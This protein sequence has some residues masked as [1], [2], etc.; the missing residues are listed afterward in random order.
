MALQVR[1]VQKSGVVSLSSAVTT[2]LHEGWQPY[3]SPYVTA[4]AAAQVMFLPDDATP[5]P[6]A[7]YFLASKDGVM[8][9]GTIILERLEA[10]WNMFGE[11]LETQYGPTQAMTKGKFTIF[12]PNLGFGDGQPG[13]GEGGGLTEAEVKALIDAAIAALELPEEDQW[14]TYVDKGDQ[15]TLQ[16]AGEQANNAV[17]SLRV[18][19]EHKDTVVLDS[20]NIYTDEAIAKIPI[21]DWEGDFTRIEQ[22]IDELYN[23]VNSTADP[24]VSID[25]A[26]AEAIAHTDTVAADLRSE[27]NSADVAV[28]S[29]SK[30]Y[31]DAQL[32]TAK[33]NSERY[34]DNMVEYGISQMQ[35]QIS[36]G[37]AAA[38]IYADQQIAILDGSVDA[39]MSDLSQSLQASISSSAAD[40]Q[41]LAGQHADMG[42]TFVLQAANQYTDEKVASAATASTSLL[43]ETMEAVIAGAVERW[44]AD[45]KTVLEAAQVAYR[46]G[47]FTTPTGATAAPVSLAASD[48]GN[49]RTTLRLPAASSVPDGFTQQVLNI[50][51][52]V[53]SD[54]W[55]SQCRVHLDDEDY[56]EGYKVHT[57]RSVISASFVL[58][59]GGFATVVLDKTKKVWFYLGIATSPNDGMSPT[60]KKPESD[61]PIS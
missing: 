3:G 42:D 30:S 54:E 52:I 46:K 12:M 25:K 19:M 2:A 24:Q 33:E 29:A 57:T 7:E 15:D 26:K 53:G 5:A 43:N 17:E 55:S 39:R 23:V 6:D 21:K 31:T 27:F 50:T 16:S 36:A 51:G 35:G 9:L 44:E 32:K 13:G 47:T 37:T 1:L 61:P 40:T 28:L 18:A 45:D 60:G 48:A 58:G 4:A 49:A 59:V 56:A 20:A 41:A 38:T 22:N 11:P 14:K 34:T 10:G 8:A